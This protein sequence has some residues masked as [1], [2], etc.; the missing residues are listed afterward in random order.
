MRGTSGGLVT[1]L[2]LGGPAEGVTTTGLEYP[3]ANETLHEGSTRGVSNLLVGAE[4]T[5]SVARGVLLAVRPPKDD[6]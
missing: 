2:P 3:L 6:K 4:A 1:L 5:V